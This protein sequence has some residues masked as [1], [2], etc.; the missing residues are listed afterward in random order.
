VVGE[1]TKKTEKEVP[2]ETREETRSPRKGSDIQVLGKGGFCNIFSDVKRGGTEK[3]KIQ[4][5][6]KGRKDER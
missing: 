1:K 2:P 6:G 5:K 3:M 4:K